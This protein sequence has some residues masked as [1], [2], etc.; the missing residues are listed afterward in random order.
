MS[1]PQTNGHHILSPDAE[2]FSTPPSTPGPSLDSH[3]VRPSLSRRSSRPT[4]LHLD[5]KQS[6]WNTNIELYPSSPADPHS[7][8]NGAAPPTI[9]SEPT[10]IPPSPK[11]AQAAHKAM[12]SPCFVH[13]HLD[14]GAHLT[15]WL[16][17][18]FY[19]TESND[20]GVAKSL[21]RLSNSNQP[22]N[23]LSPRST[24]YTSGNASDDDDE[25]VGS[26]TK[27]LADTAVGVREMSKQLGMFYSDPLRSSS[28]E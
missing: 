27:H 22:G 6:D 20:V 28:N 10:V 11:T 24:A 25:F 16:N 13:S 26:L 19:S 14:K 5:R 18:R 9:A 21:K 2:T 17:N 12:T 7:K 1:Q 3:A 8:L 4:S 15:D 23:L